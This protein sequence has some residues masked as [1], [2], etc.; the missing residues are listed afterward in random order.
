MARP[1][2]AWLASPICNHMFYLQTIC[3][4]ICKLHFTETHNCALSGS[5]KGQCP[6]LA[7]QSC[8]CVGNLFKMEFANRFANSLQIGDGFA[9]TRRWAAQA[10]AR[11]GPGAGRARARARVQGR[12][13]G[14]RGQAR[15]PHWPGQAA[16]L[17]RS[18]PRLCFNA[19]KTAC[20]TVSS[21]AQQSH[22]PWLLAQDAQ[23]DVYC[24]YNALQP[25]S[26]ELKQDTEL[27]LRS[28]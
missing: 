13:R 23:A 9:T 19:A 18:Q 1:G 3:K 5:R 11:A 17:A 27:T 24:K 4:P 22:R 7:L 6:L 8:A 26:R 21:L 14:P 10:R 20:K 2:L 16:R 25:L 12:A 15:V 28:V